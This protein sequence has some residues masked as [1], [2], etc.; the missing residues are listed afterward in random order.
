M[1]L[2]E[3]SLR[4][5]KDLSPKSHPLRP[6]DIQLASTG[7]P[8]TLDEGTRKSKPL[9][10][11]TAT[12]PKDSRGNK[13]PLDRDI[14]FTAPDEGTTKSTPRPEGTKLKKGD[15]PTSSTIPHTEASKTDSSSDNIL[16]KYDDTLTITEQQLVKYLRKVSHVLF[17]IITKDQWEKHEEATIHYEN[18]KAFIDDYYNENIAHRDQTDQLMEAFM[19]SLKK[20]ST[21]ITD[22]YKGLKVITQLFK[23][24]KILVK[25]DPTTNKKIKEASKTLAKISTQT[26]EILSLVR[27]VILTF[28]ITDTPANVEGENATY[29]TIEEP[30]SYTEGE[31][32]AN[33]QE[34]PEEPKQSIDANTGFICSSTHPPITKAQPITIIHAQPSVPQREGK[35]IATDDQVE[36]QRKLFKASSIVRPN[37]NKPEK[38]KK[39]KEEARLNAISKTELIKVVHEEAKKIGIH[40][41]EAISSKAD[42]L[43]KKAQDTEHEVLKRQRTKKVRKSLGLRKHK[44]DSYLWTVSSRLK[45]KPI[46]DIKIHLK[47]KPVVITVYKG[48]DGRNFNV[49]KPFSLDHLKHMELEP[50]T[51]IPGLECNRTLPENVPFVN[52]MVIEEPEYVI[53]FTNEFGDQAF[54]RWSDIDKV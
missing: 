51:R 2:Q 42:E 12:H 6:R 46:T 36:D 52:N 34:K 37:P 28:A 23:D 9:P 17:E 21:T 24:I 48:T 27:S 20:S 43:F 30:P 49:H 15:K 25:D 53:F 18:L 3:H 4:R 19:S 16:K 26:T 38:I 13:Q 31:T 39:A 32:D 40:L 47:I 45:P 8:S 11:G 29:T 22:L 10:E 44:Y 41:K 14:T 33:I 1:R 35:R 5:A 54:Q 50:E 7:L